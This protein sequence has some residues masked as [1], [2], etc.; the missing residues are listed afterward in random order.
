MYVLRWQLNWTSWSMSDKVNTGLESLLSP[1]ERLSWTSLLQLWF[2][3]LGP[4]AARGGEWGRWCSWPSKSRGTIGERSRSKLM[5][6][7]SFTFIPWLSLLKVILYFG[8]C[9]FPSFYVKIYV[10][11]SLIHSSL[12]SLTFFTKMH[13]IPDILTNVLIII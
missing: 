10:F 4:C 9:K 11:D 7:E 1:R 8:L 3:W 6:Q 5:L 12:I 13:K 2:H